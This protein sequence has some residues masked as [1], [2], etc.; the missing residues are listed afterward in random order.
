MR[1][2]TGWSLLDIVPLNH[3]RTHSVTH[4]LAKSSGNQNLQNIQK[5]KRYWYGQFIYWKTWV[6]YKK[7]RG[8]PFV[9]YVTRGH[10][11]QTSMSDEEFGGHL[12]GSI[13]SNNTNRPRLSAFRFHLW[14][15][16]CVLRVFSCQDY[17]IHYLKNI[18]T[19]KLIVGRLLSVLLVPIWVRIY[20]VLVMTWRC[21]Q[22]GMHLEVA[23]FQTG[24]AT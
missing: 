16:R 6:S 1:F 5:Y 20:E 24:V 10:T 21:L 12:E 19:W 13:I 11:Q 18:A 7:N 4:L 15:V 3:S 17:K 14:G 23:I 9:G 22:E 8:L 2:A